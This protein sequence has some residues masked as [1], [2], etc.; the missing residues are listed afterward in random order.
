MPYVLP[1]DPRRAIWECP[2]ASGSFT[3]N[4]KMRRV[5]LGDFAKNPTKWDAG[6]TSYAAR[7]FVGFNVKGKPAWKIQ[8]LIKL[9]R[10]VR[11]AQGVQ[12]DSSFV[13]QKGVYTHRKGGKA[14]VIQEDGAQVILIKMESET[15]AEF[16]AN[17]ELLAEII[18]VQMKQKE[19]VVEE[20]KNG[21]VQ[22]TRGI[23][24]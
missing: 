4:G 15:V 1:A 14:K 12:E 3:P 6:E 20:Q 10:N 8:D 11:R 7:L 24:A 13:A 9:V 16:K 22:R 2:Q 19:V 23:E 5:S 18:C 17:V 21:L